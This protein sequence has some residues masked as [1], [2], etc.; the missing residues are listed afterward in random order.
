MNAPSQSAPPASRD[1]P[2]ESSQSSLAAIGSSE[3]NAQSTDVPDDQFSQGA[4]PSEFENQ[5]RVSVDVAN[6]GT[7]TSLDNAHHGGPISLD[8]E[9]SQ[10]QQEFRALSEAVLDAA[11]VAS[12][13]AATATQLGVDLKSST[14]ELQDLATI[15]RKRSVI[16][17]SVSGALM[18]LGLTFMVAT[19]VRMSARVSELDAMLL[20]VGKRTVELNASVQ[21]LDVTAEKFREVSQKVA[22]LSES[23]ESV[24]AMYQQLENK[25][26]GVFK[27]TENVAQQVPEQTA[28]QVA[29]NSDNM[30]KQIQAVN[31]RIQ[32]QAG[33]VQTLQ[34]QIKTLSGTVGNVDALKRD[35]QAL[36]VLQRERYLEALQRQ[37]QTA[38]TRAPSVQYPRPQQGSPS[39]SPAAAPL[40]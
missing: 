24:K 25:L 12:K 2:P 15:M 36:V 14:R 19:G 32:S 34:A 40:N 6:E 37:K 16:V 29:A 39:E 20:A 22:A 13:S 17:L 27:Q 30:L 4:A 31:A 35:V 1:L 33:A 21:A 26:D 8:L 5:D 7:D 38:P 10:T 18:F 23:Q 28:K 9:P 3:Q 11:D